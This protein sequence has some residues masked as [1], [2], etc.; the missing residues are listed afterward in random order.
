MAGQGLTPFPQ[1]MPK[2]NYFNLH[3]AIKIELYSKEFEIKITSNQ[4]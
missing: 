1:S 2:P 4:Q 3:A